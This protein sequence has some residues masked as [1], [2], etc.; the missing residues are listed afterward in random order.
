[1]QT[2]LKKSRGKLG[3]DD[4][5]REVYKLLTSA[6]DKEFFYFR[7][8][9]SIDHILIDEF[10]DTSIA[11]FEILKPLIDEIL[12]GKG[13]KEDKSF[14]YVGDQKQS[15]YRFRGGNPHLFSAVRKLYGDRIKT[16]T[17]DVNRRSL[18]NLIDFVNKVFK[19]KI[20]DFIEQ[21]PHKEESD[22][23]VEVTSG[24]DVIEIVCDQVS[25]L[26]ESGIKSDNIAILTRKNDDGEKAAQALREK[27]GETLSVVAETA[28]KL[29]KTLE[30]RAIIEALKYL[31]CDRNKLYEAN[32]R[33]LLDIPPNESL[34]E[35]ENIYRNGDRTP[36]DI[37]VEIARKYSLGSL[38]TLRF[39]EYCATQSSIDELLF[40]V[41]SLDEAAS[42]ESQSGLKVTTVH[43]SKGLEFDVVIVMDT[44]SRD[45]GGSDKLLFDFEGVKLR[46][47]YWRQEGRENVDDQYAQA[48]KRQKE[49]SKR[50]DL[51]ALYVSF[52]RARRILLI[53]KN[54][55]LKKSGEEKST[56]APLELEDIK[57]GVLSAQTAREKA[58]KPDGIVVKISDFGRQEVP[59]EIEKENGA[60]EAR[61]FGTAFHYAIETLGMFERDNLNSAF[62]SAQ[63]R[64]GFLIPNKIEHIKERLDSLLNCEEFIAL[65]KNRT[66]VKEASLAY[67]GEIMRFDLLVK[68]GDQW[69]V[70][71]FKTGAKSSDHEKQVLR[72]ID[73]LKNTTKQDAHGFI[74][75]VRGDSDVTLEKVKG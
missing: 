61:I 57:I 26:L 73:A 54:A 38:D 2:E 21:K 35:L 66:F 28:V 20:P 17:L 50:D 43:K 74:A 48:A 19:D 41:D 46:Q 47:I 29:I 7:M 60:R 22:G 75:Y 62:F 6:F 25:R 58:K 1:S 53:A 42:P 13:I 23:Y 36:L 63:N 37:C 52:T 71:D 32:F 59:I 31:Y 15:I 27:F 8:D 45:H 34:K 44:L 49:E 10:Q 33:T 14:F 69:I 40:N 30:V 16:K 9:G 70:I 12:A 65:V 11:Q 68:N 64:F 5:T 67:K 18:K 55:E 39:L 4:V 24:E 51:N 72:Y 56:F 3:Y